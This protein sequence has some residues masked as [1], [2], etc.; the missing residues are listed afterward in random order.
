MKLWRLAVRY[1]NY[2]WHLESKGKTDIV[3]F[4]CEIRGFHYGVT[5]D[6]NPCRL[7]QELR[8]FWRWREQGQYLRFHI[9]RRPECNLPS[10][11]SVYRLSTQS[12]DTRHKPF[13]SNSQVSLVLRYKDFFI[14]NS[15]QRKII[16]Q[17]LFSLIRWSLESYSYTIRWI[18][19]KNATI[20]YG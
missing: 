5:E 14:S 16:Q 13:M 4:R 17:I 6:S 1:V 2:S 18:S 20:N 3:S 19:S 7:R 8:E 12:S 15:F 11:N 9:D 10:I